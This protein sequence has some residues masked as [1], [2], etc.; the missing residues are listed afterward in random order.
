MHKNILVD[1][2]G[3]FVDFVAGFYQLTAEAHPELVAH[4]PDRATQKTFYIDECIEDPAMAKLAENLCNHPKLFGMLPPIEGSIDGMNYL[5]KLANK[6]GIEVMICTA[7]HKENKQSYSSKAQWIE[8]H[9]GVDWLNHTLM[10]RDKSICSGIILLDDKPEPLGAFK[11][12]WEHI[13]MDQPYN[14]YI[15]NRARFHSWTEP[16]VEMLV[17]HAADRYERYAHLMNKRGFVV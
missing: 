1:M 12:V 6:R 3:V 17:E 11:P 14:R 5:K 7:P 13:I 15:T 16:A 8:D 2:D 9:L 10:V 4:L